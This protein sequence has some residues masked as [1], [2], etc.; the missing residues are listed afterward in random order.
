MRTQTF[1]ALVLAALI[2]PALTLALPQGQE[3]AAVQKTTINLNTATI[4]QLMTLPGIGQK[5]AERILDT[6]PR[7]AASRKSK[8]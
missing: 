1:L 5:T 3:P 4:D 8:S 7:A 2:T 6:A